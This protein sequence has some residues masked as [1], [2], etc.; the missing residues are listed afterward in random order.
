M[1]SN[2]LA[3][4]LHCNLMTLLWILQIVMYDRCCFRSLLLC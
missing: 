1:R 2:D 4:S 3:F